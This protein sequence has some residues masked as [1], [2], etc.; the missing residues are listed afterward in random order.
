MTPFGLEELRCVVEYEMMNLQILI[1][2]VRTN[3]ILLDNCQRK[4]CEVEFF[5]N[6]Y[7]VAN[8]VLNVFDLLQG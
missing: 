6:Q 2:A 5:R 7:T 8:P 3:Q 1:V 4:L